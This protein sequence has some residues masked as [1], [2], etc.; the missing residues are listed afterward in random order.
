MHRILPNFRLFSYKYFISVFLR[1][2]RPQG[3]RN[4]P[5][6][7]KSSSTSLV[8][9]YSTLFVLKGLYLSVND[10][11]FFKIRASRLAFILLMIFSNIVSSISVVG[12]KFSSLPEEH[13]KHARKKSN[14]I[15]ILVNYSSRLNTI[16]FLKTFGET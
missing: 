1:P 11:I 5:I 16:F 7:S 4:G 3:K 10:S 15:L 12:K 2:R 14:L 13:C 8:L 9:T 6:F